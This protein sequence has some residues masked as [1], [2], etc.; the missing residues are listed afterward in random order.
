MAQPPIPEETGA[1]A[2]SLEETT[3]TNLT[4]GTPYQGTLAGSGQAQ[5]FIVTL[6]NPG[7][8]AVELTDTNANDE[9]EV[10]VSLGTAPT[11]DTFQYRYTSTGADQTLALAAQPGTYY[12]LVYNNLVTSPGSNYTFLVQ[13]GPFVL[14]GSTPGKVGDSQAAT[15]LVSGVFPLAYLS[16]TSYQIQFISAG[17]TAYPASPLYLSPTSLGIGSGG[18]ES[19]NGTMTM[20]GTL[21]AN[22]LAA[23][24]YS[25]KVTDD[26]GDSQTLPD[27]LTVTAGGAG[28]LKTSIS[29]PDPIGYHEAS[30]IYVTYSNVGTAPMDAPLLVLTATQNGEQGAFLSLDPS[31]AGLGYWTNTTPAGFSQTVQFL[32]SGA[33]PGILEPGE[34]IT[35]PVYYG[36]WL[37]SQWDFSRPPIYFTL[38]DLDTTNTQTLEWSSLKAGPFN[39]GSHK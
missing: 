38:G 6:A 30:T 5:L 17:G 37:H 28:V 18:T 29:M 14:T 10:Y 35:V 33:I 16:A 1:Y 27:V 23:G 11:R 3:Q 7:A 31:D 24:S 19:V 20:A 32:A 25:A 39:R 26:Q 34:S 9:N 21:P 2:F 13:G 22:A 4:L 8:L 15:L 12:I 36:G